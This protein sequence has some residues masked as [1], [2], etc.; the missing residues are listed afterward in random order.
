VEVKSV[1]RIFSCFILRKC[2]VS[3]VL[4]DHLYIYLCYCLRWF[5]HSF[6]QVFVQDFC[7]ERGEVKANPT[8]MM[9]QSLGFRAE[10]LYASSLPWSV[11]RVKAC[12]GQNDSRLG[13]CS[14]SCAKLFGTR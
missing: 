3:V 12:A 5:C 14:R 7:G 10:G 4:T 11:C 13:G 8:S 6:L 2:L 9:L 1:Y